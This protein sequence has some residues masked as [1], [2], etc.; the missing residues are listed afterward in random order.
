METGAEP[1]PAPQKAACALGMGM[2]M[3]VAV[4][5]GAVQGSLESLFPPV[6]GA[7]R[8]PLPP[9]ASL[10]QLMGRLVTVWPGPPCPIPGAMPV[11]CLF[12]GSLEGDLG[13]WLLGRGQGPPVLTQ[14]PQVVLKPLNVE[15]PHL[16]AWPLGLCGLAPPFPPSL[17]LAGGG[18]ATE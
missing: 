5:M 14:V 1:L 7:L 2:G 12:L 15:D 18:V 10:A 4:G 16:E 3:G 9:H 11:T 17:E 13:G 6:P 8:K